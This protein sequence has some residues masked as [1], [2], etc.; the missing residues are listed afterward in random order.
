MHLTTSTG[1]HLTLRLGWK[2]KNIYIYIYIYQLDNNNIYHEKSQLNRL[3]WGSLTFAPIK[4]TVRLASVG[5][6]QARPNKSIVRLASV[7][8]AQARPNYPC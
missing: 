4:S 6:A 7:G 2:K 5:L 3:V 1:S 8:L